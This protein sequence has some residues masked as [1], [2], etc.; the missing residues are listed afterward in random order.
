MG[1]T[2]AQRPNSRSGDHSELHHDSE[3]DFSSA[4]RSSPHP[5]HPN[6]RATDAPAHEVVHFL[7]RS[8]G[9]EFPDHL[10]VHA[11]QACASA[12]S[13]TTANTE[14]VQTKLARTPIR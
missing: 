10:R 8:R 7:V 9:L 3:P 1:T 4:R 12:N 14:L 13:A 6:W 2:A 5:V 11:P